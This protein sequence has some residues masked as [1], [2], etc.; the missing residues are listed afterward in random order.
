MRD[1][2]PSDSQPAY[3]LIFADLK[4]RRYTEDVRSWLMFLWARKDAESPWVWV[5]CGRSDEMADLQSRLKCSS[6][7]IVPWDVVHPGAANEP[8]FCWSLTAA[9]HGRYRGSPKCD[10]PNKPTE[11]E[12]IERIRLGLLEGTP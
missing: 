4:G 3:R 6:S 12:Q 5:A 9:M 11:A 1:V 2:D 8:E 7:V 10:S